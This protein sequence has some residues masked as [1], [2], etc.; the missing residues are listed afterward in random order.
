MRKLVI[1]ALFLFPLGE[2]ARF[3]FGQGF[4]IKPLDAA[5]LI[6]VFLWLAIKILKKQ[7]IKQASILISI[8]FFV[9]SG[10]FPLVV[11]SLRLSQN[12]LFISFSYLLRWLTYAG[13]FFVISDFDKEFKKKIS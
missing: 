6:L 3:D 10:S 7:K 5:V 11:N 13:V 12:E 8:L 1:F 9:L 2:I 4:A